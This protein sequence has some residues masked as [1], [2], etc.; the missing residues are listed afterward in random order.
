LLATF[1]GTAVKYSYP[2]HLSTRVEADS[3]G[4]V[5]RK[6]GH[7]PFG[8][9]WYET[10]SNG[11]VTSKW[12][13]TSYERDSTSDT[14]YAIFR[15]NSWRY[16]RFLQADPLGGDISDPQS[17]NRFAYVGNDPVNFVDPMGLDG[18]PAGVVC[19]SAT[20]PFNGT[21]GS[22]GP[23]T[24]PQL[25]S[26]LSCV[27]HCQSVTPGPPVPNTIPLPAPPTPGR[28]AD[29]DIW[30]LP[31]ASILQFDTGPFSNGLG[32]HRGMLLHV[33]GDG[34][35]G[36]GTQAD[37]EKDWAA[38]NLNVPGDPRGA[39]FAIFNLSIAI[40]NPY[41]GTLI[42]WNGTLSYDREGHWYSS[43]RGA[44]FGKSASFISFSAGFG[45]LNQASVPTTTQLQKFLSGHSF[46]FL[47]G[48]GPAGGI[49]WTPGSGTATVLGV[50][51]PQL[52]LSYNYSCTGIRLTCR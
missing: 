41:T 36:G 23:L 44:T 22:T 39:D 48:G 42:G 13:F 10:L 46:N 4:A 26:T 33:D 21:G 35:G 14:D 24:L 1:A 18:C 43:W 25:V 29:P 31:S 27:P 2:D 47:L 15:N 20:L 5:L 6:T 51:S 45:W 30:S 32:G 40:P 11:G 7:L 28:D 19:V 8:D 34:S 50:A 12:K 49:S 17:L 37:R 16:G 9:A 52:G 38:R 3:T